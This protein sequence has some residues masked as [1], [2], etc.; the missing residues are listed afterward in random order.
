MRNNFLG[1]A[2]VTGGAG[3]LTITTALGLALPSTGLPVAGQACEYS[4]VQYADATYATVVKSES[5]FGTLSSNVLTRY[6]RTTWDGTTYSQNSPTALSFATTFVLVT[7]SPIAEGGA[8]SIA[9]TTVTDFAASAFL[10]ETPN[11]PANFLDAGVNLTTVALAAGGLFAVPIRLEAGFPITSLGARITTA[12]AAGTLLAVC[13]AATDPQSGL[14]GVVLSAV[15][16][17]AA[18]TTGN[19]SGSVT[20]KL[21]SPGW[22]WACF[23]SDGAPTLQACLNTLPTSLGA[24]DSAQRVAKCLT[25]SAGVTYSGTVFAV[26][27]NLAAGVIDNGS[28]IRNNAAPPVLTYS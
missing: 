2:S 11:I 22:Y 23:L 26:G 6:P 12:A 4:I 24:F 8:T 18:Y 25:I 15:H 9:K 21:Y 17:I 20:G 28:L 14:P 27:T 13:I 5:G 3:D 10:S 19:V 16:G 1:G 7:V